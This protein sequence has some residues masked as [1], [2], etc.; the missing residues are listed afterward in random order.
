MCLCVPWRLF[1]SLHPPV[2]CPPSTV[3]GEL[4]CHGQVVLWGSRRSIQLQQQLCTVCLA[5]K[6][7]ITGKL[8]SKFV[9]R[10]VHII[11]CA[12][13]HKYES[14]Y[15]TRQTKVGFLCT[16]IRAILYVVSSVKDDSTLAA[17]SKRV[18]G[19]QPHNVV[20]DM[21]SISF[22]MVEPHIY[23]IFEIKI[24]KETKKNPVV[25]LWV[26]HAV[27]QSSRIWLG[28]RRVTIL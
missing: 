21:F 16:D 19:F 28:K 14:K 23:F 13:S 7:I 1:T 17:G 2:S 10:D 26:W 4:C 20:M 6:N 24:I 12:E 27:D 8:K 9:M 15:W 11:M 3:S 22:W 18:T 5:A 25:P